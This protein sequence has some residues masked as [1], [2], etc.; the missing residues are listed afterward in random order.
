M[1]VVILKMVLCVGS[2]LFYVNDECSRGHCPPDETLEL[3]RGQG[4]VV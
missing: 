1:A 4:C 2:E 3:M